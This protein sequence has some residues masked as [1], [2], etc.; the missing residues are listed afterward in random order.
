MDRMTISAQMESDVKQEDIEVKLAGFQVEVSVRGTK[1][2][3]LTGELQDLVR[4]APASWWVLSGEEGSPGLFCLQL[5]KLKHASWGGPWYTGTL[6]PKKK[7]RFWWTDVAKKVAEEQDKIIK[8]NQYEVVPPG[9]PDEE[10]SAWYPPTP[11]NVF[12][13]LSDKYLA[14][15]DDLVLGTHC[16]QDKRHVYLYVHFDND[17]LDY[18]E[19]TVPFEDLFGADFTQNSVYVFIRGDDQNPI[20]NATF[21]GLISP[22]AATWKMT[23]EETYRARQKSPSAPSPALMITIPKAEG[24]T[25]EWQEIFQACWQHRLMVKNSNEYDELSQAAQYLQYADDVDP[26]VRAELQSKA[27]KLQT[28]QEQR[29]DGIPQAMTFRRSGYDIESP[30]Y[31]EN[32]YDYVRETVKNQGCVSAPKVIEVADY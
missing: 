16:K 30:D 21:N 3:H 1:V 26:M 25:Y 23:T 28:W 27:D 10:D 32:V 20:I 31:W 12:T 9:R 29:F 14:S 2:K 4:A 13:P 6:H 24:S 17:A 22:E 11:A 19:Q 5:V 7:N 8:L 18:F 15:P